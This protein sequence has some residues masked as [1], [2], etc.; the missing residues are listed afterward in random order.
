M[1]SIGLLAGGIAHDFNNLMAGIIGT[2]DLALLEIDPS[3]SV[4]EDLQNIRKQ[5]LRGATLTKQLLAFSRRQ[6]LEPELVNLNDVVHEVE[7]FIGRAIGRHI[8]LTFL[9]SS[10]LATVYVDPVQIEQ[11]LL[12]LCINARDAMPEGGRLL[13]T[14]TNVTLDEAFCREHVGVQPGEYVQLIVTDTGTGMD[15]ETAQHIFEP[16]FTTKEL[17]KGTGLGLAMAYGIIT[18][19]NGL[20]F[21]ESELGHGSTFTIL[22]PVA[23]SAEIVERML[24]AWQ[25]DNP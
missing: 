15:Q 3:A 8:T 22:L 10:N 2:A 6:V 25:S 18:Q 13:I 21:V 11:V 14:T 7:H 17:G 23:S 4:R 24:G 20:I 12:N 9:P 5:A 16:F 19:H 1:E